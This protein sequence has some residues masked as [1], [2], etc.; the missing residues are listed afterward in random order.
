MED[1]STLVAALEDTAKGSL[2][3]EDVVKATEEGQSEA[4]GRH[5][6]DERR[7]RRPSCRGGEQERQQA[8]RT[9]RESVR[10]EDTKISPSAQ[11]SVSDEEDDENDKEEDE[12]EDEDE[13][14]HAGQVSSLRKYQRRLLKKAERGIAKREHTLV[15]LPTGGGKTML[16]GHLVRRFIRPRR[17][18]ASHALFVVN[19]N[20]LVDQTARSMEACGLASHEFGFIKAGYKRTPRTP[21]QI[22]SIQTLFSKA[23][24]RKIDADASDALASIRLIVVDEAHCMLANQYSQLLDRFHDAI[25][26]GLTATPFRMRDDEALSA[27]F[28]RLARGPS[29]SRMI[30]KGYL[31]PP[32]VMSPSTAPGR[33]LTG[34]VAQMEET[35]ESALQRWLTCCK[36]TM[37]IVFC[38]TVKQSKMCVSKFLDAGIDAEHLDGTTSEKHRQRVFNLAQNGE[39]RVLSSVG[40][41]SEGFDL[42]CIET[43][44]LLRPTESR[45]LYVQQVGRGLRPFSGKKRCIVLDEVGNTYRHGPVDGPRGFEW[46]NN[47]PSAES[48][49][50]K[51]HR[52]AE[53]L[54]QRLLRGCETPK[55]AALL[56][57]ADKRKYCL[58]CEEKH[59]ARAHAKRQ[60]ENSKTA[61]DLADE[62]ASGLSIKTNKP[63]SSSGL[64]AKPK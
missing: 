50:A 43:V 15:Y 22:A 44:I 47:A 8:T 39:L 18:D 60:S 37:T 23:E 57:R 63:A 12:D 21:L 56:H 17:I 49:D 25:V 2:K 6:D 30:R 13:E 26:V 52:K 54:A 36:D 16:A 28:P 42:P 59:R 64:V 48:D 40:V 55:C 45:G 35:V 61:D 46:E 14:D 7:H 1:L 31:V 53:A 24:L 58:L 5:E 34:K 11:S 3:A 10:I 32:V 29:V 20:A 19:R 27:V 51:A 41:L 4:E 9:E 62:L 33:K 38:T